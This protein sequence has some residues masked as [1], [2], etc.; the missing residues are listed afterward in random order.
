MGCLRNHHERRN[1]APVVIS[2]RRVLNFF[3][4]EE[5]DEE[6][7]LSANPK[8][9]SYRQVQK[10]IKL[11]VF[12]RSAKPLSSFLLNLAHLANSS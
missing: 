11:L 5:R 9:V 6:R 1:W 8:S 10:Y 4:N 12:S 7:V 3:E 2:Q